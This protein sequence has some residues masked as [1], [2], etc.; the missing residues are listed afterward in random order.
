[1][2]RQFL[3]MPFHQKI[4]LFESVNYLTW[5]K[6]TSIVNILLQLFSDQV[7]HD[8][9]LKLNDKL[10]SIFQ[11]ANPVYIPATTTYK[12]PTYAGKK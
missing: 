3:L 7:K 2:M 11:G 9:P 5:E 6:G 4:Y 1:M 12:N 10:Y 8:F